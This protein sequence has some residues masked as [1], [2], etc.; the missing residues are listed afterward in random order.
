MNTPGES[1]RDPETQDQPMGR[2]ANPSR[3]PGH[4][5]CNSRFARRNPICESIQ[6]MRL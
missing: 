2:R 3:M 5:L 6:G 4:T 1:R